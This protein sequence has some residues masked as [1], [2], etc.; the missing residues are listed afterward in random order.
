MARKEAS[1][2]ER[3]VITPRFLLRLAVIA[4]LLVSAL[5]AWHKTEQFLIRDARF[6]VALPEYGIESPSIQ[7]SGVRHSSRL[8]ILH[9]F[10][11][12]LGR[13]LYLLPLKQRREQLLEVD[14]VK[15]ASIARIWPNRILVQIQ[16]R[17]PVAFLNLPG[18][19]PGFSRAALI[20]AEG[21]I[22]S[23]PAQA[24]FNLPV[25]LGIKPDESVFE[26]RARVRR[27]VTLM[28][29]VG[30]LGERVSEVN[31]ADTDNLRVTARAG[32]RAVVLLMGDHN[33]AKRFQN[34][35][36]HYE[37]IQERLANATVLDVRLEDRITVVEENGNR[38]GPGR[39]GAR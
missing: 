37:R 16:E 39:E 19:R 17:E 9:E 6:A 1:N 14:W 23:V 29:E 35:V 12:D 11:P 32:R 31:V 21:R 8:Q 27:L 38:G 4:V 7:L 13:S 15:D 26:R 10:S 20:D 36:N 28:K 3:R 34:F 25:A 18:E 22:M 30:P 24:R 5:Y 33:F 2:N